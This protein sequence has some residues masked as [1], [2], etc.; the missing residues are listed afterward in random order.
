[1][2]T[3]T[4]LIYVCIPYAW[5]SAWHL[6]VPPKCLLNEYVNEQMDRQRNGV[7]QVTY[8]IALLNRQGESWRNNGTAQCVMGVESMVGG[9][10]SERRFP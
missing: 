7:E 10:G 1:M 8:L 2:Q 9:T 5:H 3:R 4:H 6:A